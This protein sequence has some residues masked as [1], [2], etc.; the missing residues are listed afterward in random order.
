[1]VV[2]AVVVAGARV[3]GRWARCP[4]GF[5]F[6]SLWNSLCREPSV[7]SA[8]VRRE[9]LA[10]LSAKEP[11]PAG[12]CRVA[13]AENFLSVEALPRGKQ[14]LPRG[15]GLSAE[16]SN[17]VVW[18]INCARVASNRRWW[19]WRGC[20]WTCGTGRCV[21]LP[22]SPSPACL[23]TLT[24]EVAN[25][26]PGPRPYHDR[27]MGTELRQA[28]HR[29]VDLLS[30]PQFTMATTDK[31][32]QPNTMFSICVAKC[33]TYNPITSPYSPTLPFLFLRW[34]IASPLSHTHISH[35]HTTFSWK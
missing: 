12:R 23:Q 34:E 15:L 1:V 7:L 4:A 19:P 32:V 6:F 29:P 33:T 28:P 27:H 18:Q 16:A 17:P 25:P 31:L 5:L 8:H 26:C 20:L 11:L 30:L 14:P 9:D 3:A 35:T 10:W 21:S 2:E 22:L 13:S 24:E